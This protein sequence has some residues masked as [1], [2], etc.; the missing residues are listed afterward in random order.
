MYEGPYAEERQTPEGGI[1][2]AVIPVSRAAHQFQSSA[3]YDVFIA[4][5]GAVFEYG[6]A[7][8]RVKGK[9]TPCDRVAFVQHCRKHG[10]EAR[11]HATVCGVQVALW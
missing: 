2:A 7:T 8:M 3:S 6:P 9:P 11:T 10:V 1:P 5:S 4:P